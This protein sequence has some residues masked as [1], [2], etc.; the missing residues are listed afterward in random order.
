[1]ADTAKM[2]GGFALKKGDND[3]KQ[4]WGAKKHSN[5]GNYVEQLQNDL[6]TL[7]VYLS[8]VDGDFGE[9]THDAV[10]RLQ[11]NA[12]NNLN[13]IQNKA[14][15][16]ATKTYSDKVDGIVGPNTKKEINSWKTSKYIATGDLVR[17][18]A[19]KFSNISLGTGF[20]KLNH[21]DVKK[22]EIVISKSLLQYLKKANKKAADL[23]VEIKLNQ[24]MRQNGVKVSGA[25]VT[26]ASKSQHLIGHAID[27]NIVDGSNWNS[28]K[29][30]KNKKETENAKKFIK[31]MKKNGMRWG[32]DF[33]RTDTPH[34]D[35]QV[36]A[37]SD[38]YNF[39]YF[40]N[41]RMLSE[42]QKIPLKTW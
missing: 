6:K 3:K 35:R 17:V 19:N 20:K 11:W 18:K 22:D 28:S 42:K 5:K 31:A 27:C 14:N 4:T 32:G 30:F 16:T 10:K 41:Q 36:L 9:K 15:V 8:K 26:P 37:S 38:A 2:Y 23:S 29:T 25:V 40:F 34:F 33:T 24:A 1:M 12:L 7:G 21:P 13:R 39:K